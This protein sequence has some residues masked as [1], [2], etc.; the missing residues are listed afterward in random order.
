[1][2]SFFDTDDNYAPEDPGP[3]G[4]AIADDVGVDGWVESGAWARVRS[5]NVSAVA[6]DQDKHELRVRF[7]R[8]GAGSEPQYRYDRVPADVARDLFMAGSIGTY[9]AARVKG[10]YPYQKES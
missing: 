8:H 2:G 10:H 4:P 1:M 7:L 9:L 3:R 5:S 6:Y